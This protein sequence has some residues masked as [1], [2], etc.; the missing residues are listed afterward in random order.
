MNLIRRDACFGIS[1]F[2][3]R[4]LKR[5]PKNNKRKRQR[6]SK[7][8]EQ[9]TESSAPNSSPTLNPSFSLHSLPVIMSICDLVACEQANLWVTRERC[10]QS[11]ETQGQLVGAGKSLNGREKIRAERIQCMDMFVTFLRGNFFSCPFRLFPASTNCPCVSEEGCAPAGR[12]LVL[13]RSSVWSSCASF[14]KVILPP[15]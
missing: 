9:R 4:G 7:T 5:L 12:S 1:I 13:R 2:W 15:G 3:L 8:K 11:S 10:A 14:P 6:Y